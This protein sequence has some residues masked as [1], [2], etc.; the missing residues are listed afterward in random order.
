MAG[1]EALEALE[2]LW[3]TS[4]WQPANS[5]TI[6]VT[7]CTGPDPLT[8]VNHVAH[9]A[10]SGKVQIMRVSQPLWP[11]ETDTSSDHA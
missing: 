2:E 11:P 8:A 5:S 6:A 7:N 4:T 9:A 3:V 1:S 10:F